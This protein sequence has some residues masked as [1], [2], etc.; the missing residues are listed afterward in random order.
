VRKALFATVVAGGIAPFLAIGCSSNNGTSLANNNSSTDWF[1]V[2]KLASLFKSDEGQMSST[3]VGNP[4]DPT[5]LS[6]EGDP[7]GADLYVAYAKIH[8]KQNNLA[9][10]EAYYHRAL[11]ASPSDLPALLG[12]A[13]LLDRQGKLD[14]ATSYYQQAAQHHPDDATAHNDL[15]LCYARRGMLNESLAELSRAVELEPQKQ[16][17]RNNIATVCV[18]LRQPQ[19]ALEH[20]MATDQPAVAH[21]NLACLLQ[22]R[23]H[24]Q[25]AASHF[26]Q[27]ARLDPNLPGAQELAGQLG[28][29]QA[30]ARIANVR[31]VD[32]SPPQGS[33]LHSQRVATAQVGD[34][35]SAQNASNTVAG[36]Q[37]W[38]QSGADRNWAAYD[39]SANAPSQR[40]GSAPAGGAASSAASGSAY[41]AVPPSPDTASTYALPA[42]AVDALP[43]VE[44][45]VP[46][47]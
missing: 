28:A 32:H 9:G 36:G 41:A 35:P 31:P 20:L 19:Q 10:A 29:P 14:E 15:G 23:G 3:D 46:R 5:S 6:F 8:E 12:Y 11:E 44:Q 22:Q 16:L 18:E 21:Y 38:P 1:G 26:A 33:Q 17:Y 25:V 40:A 42:S 24:S 39:V 43:P 34:L 4:Y 30:E 13:H 7:P 2:G 27:A 45:P 47:Y 37:R